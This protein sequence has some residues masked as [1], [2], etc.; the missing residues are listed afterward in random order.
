VFFLAELE[1]QPD[2]FYKKQYAIVIKF[3]LMEF[4]QVELRASSA[5]R[6]PIIETAQTTYNL[7]N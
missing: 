2:E 1:I 5:S 4:V 6:E 3:T 7:H